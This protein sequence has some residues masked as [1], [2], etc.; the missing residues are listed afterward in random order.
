MLSLI[1]LALLRIFQLLNLFKMPFLIEI[2]W[3]YSNTSPKHH[4]IWTDPIPFISWIS[5]LIFLSI[6]FIFIIAIIGLFHTIFKLSFIVRIRSIWII[7]LSKFLIW[8]DI[9]SHSYFFESIF[10]PSIF[11]RM[12]SLCLFIIAFLYGIK[13]SSFINI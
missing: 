2:V 6:K 4:Y 1:L 9:I 12:V 13:I 8:Q 11:I 3:Y 5:L 10:T 7:L